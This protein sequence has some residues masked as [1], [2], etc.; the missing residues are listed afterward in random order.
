MAGYCRGPVNGCR[1]DYGAV[2]PRR[3]RTPGS[4]DH[5]RRPQG[6]HQ[7]MDCQGQPG[8]RTR[9]RLARVYM[10]GKRKGYKAH[11]CRNA[12]T[13]SRDEMKIVAAPYLPAAG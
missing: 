6:L 5:G 8:S 13:W 1:E 10:F 7:A 12:E 4:R 2:P 3:L 9:Y 11:G